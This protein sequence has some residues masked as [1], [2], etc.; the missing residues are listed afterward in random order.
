MRSALEV[1]SM[2][3]AIPEY[4]RPMLQH[5]TLRQKAAYPDVIRLAIGLAVF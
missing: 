3:A 5:G 4:T 1:L 2:L